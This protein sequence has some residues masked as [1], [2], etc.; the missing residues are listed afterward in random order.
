[1]LTLSWM[2]LAAAARPAP[3]EID[4]PC[5]YAVGD[6][7]TYDVTTR[8]TQ[9]RPEGDVERRLEYRATFTV[10]SVADAEVRLTVVEALT[11]VPSGPEGDLM[12]R[13]GEVTPPTE[14]RLRPEE[15]GWDI[16][17]TNAEA[18]AA[19][20]QPAL[21]AFVESLVADLPD[22]SLADTLR[23]QVRP[24]LAA[25]SSPA[26]VA[27]EGIDL[28]S[29][30]IPIVCGPFPTSPPPVPLTLPNVLGGD[31][32]PG[33]FAIRFEAPRRSPVLATT[34]FTLDPD[35]DVWSTVAPILEPMGLDRSAVDGGAFA[36]SQ[37]TSSQLDRE[38]GWA[39]EA[40]ATEELRIGPI[41]RKEH[42]T[43]VRVD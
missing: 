29:S 2:A 26:V 4:L 3:A 7:H 37:G 8:T 11:T 16:D 15:T 27:Q 6:T 38:T 19:A 32:F 17:V 1:M 31:G 12:R 36:A 21:D 33:T 39:I 20:M 22:P 23:D 42:K 41:G 9:F 13:L 10:T 25:A 40:S 14:L 28:A 24:M 18:Q 35:F 34:S 43:F 30:V 5:S